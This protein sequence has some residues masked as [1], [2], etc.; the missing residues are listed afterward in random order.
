VAPPFAR[1][2]DF[3]IDKPA[4]RPCPHLGRASGCDIHDDLRGR[5]FPGCDVYDCFGAGQR[6]VQAV[7]GADWRTD[8]GVAGRLFAALPVLRQLHELL[9]YLAEVP[10]LAAAAPLHGGARALAAEVTTAARA[11]DLQDV[12]AGGL[13]GRTGELLA[14][15][16][17]VVRAALPHRARDRRGA[18]LAG[19]RLSGADLRGASLRGALLLGAA[20]DG[21]DLRGADLLGAD[22]R[23]A[24]VRGAD[25][26]GAL[27]LTRPQL[28]AAVG[29]AAT[30]LPG[31]AE[32]PAHWR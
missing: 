2:A 12:D 1:S 32:R 23:G 11:V 24:D 15:V 26:R 18:D 30:R 29:D 14:R 31:W 13:T 6:L 8:P 25:L 28:T 16:S 10:T 5:G 9:W 21:A 22:L 27:F 17:E 7:P 20:L 4:G 19:A 3:A